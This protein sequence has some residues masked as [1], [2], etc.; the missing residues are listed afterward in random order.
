MFDPEEWQ[1]KLFEIL[2][3]KKHV[4]SKQFLFYDK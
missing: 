2:V 3:P 4:S 1:L